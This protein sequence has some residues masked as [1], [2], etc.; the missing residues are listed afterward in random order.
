MKPESVSLVSFQ[1][2]YLKYKS[3]KWIIDKYDQVGALGNFLC[4]G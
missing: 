2:V 1:S 3:K 4:S